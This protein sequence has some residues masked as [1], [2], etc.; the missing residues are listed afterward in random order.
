MGTCYV[1]KH[2]AEI[3]QVSNKIKQTRLQDPELLQH[4]YIYTIH[5]TINN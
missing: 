3:L 4:A 2:S 5:S 1:Y